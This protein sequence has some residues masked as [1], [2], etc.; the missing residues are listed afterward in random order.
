VLKPDSRVLL[1]TADAATV[2][3]PGAAR[4][5]AKGSNPAPRPTIAV[6]AKRRCRRDQP[7]SIILF[8]PVS[9]D[10]AYAALVEIEIWLFRVP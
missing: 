9:F 1:D 4:A 8:S 10:A 6:T 2:S 5:A 7:E 3:V